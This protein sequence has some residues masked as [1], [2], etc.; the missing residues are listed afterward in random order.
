MKSR[1][2]RI[3]RGQAGQG[4]AQYGVMLSLVGMVCVIAL[5]LLMGGHVTIHPGALSS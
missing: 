4:L 5:A 1:I 2:G 3:V